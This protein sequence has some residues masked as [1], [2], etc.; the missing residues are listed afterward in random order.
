MRPGAHY[1]MGGIETD[2]WGKT[3]LEGLYAAGEVA[4]VSMH[5]ANRLASNS[6]M[7]R[8]CLLTPPMFIKIRNIPTILR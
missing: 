2:V 8:S 7:E 6:L 3:E 5:G 1:H 4:C